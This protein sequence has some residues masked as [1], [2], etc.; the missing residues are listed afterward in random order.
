[1]ETVS[2]AFGVFN[3]VAGIMLTAS[4]ICFFGGFGAY[5]FRL[6]LDS[7]NQPL[8]YM[9]YGVS[10]LFTLIVLLAIVQ[11]I[12]S[13]THIPMGNAQSFQILIAIL[14]V[15]F[16]GKWILQNMSVGKMGVM[17]KK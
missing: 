6:G 9:E 15:Y 13:I 12:Q 17:V 11:F 16:G 14:L 5:L 8:K 10:I 4:L 3:I 7:R 1:M 2:A